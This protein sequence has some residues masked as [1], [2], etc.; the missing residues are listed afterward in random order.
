MLIAL[1]VVCDN[2]VAGASDECESEAR[3][4]LRFSLL[5]NAH[6]MRL[7]PVA[8][9]EELLIAPTNAQLLWLCVVKRCQV[10]QVR[11]ADALCLPHTCQRAHLPTLASRGKVK[12]CSYE[13][14][15][16]AHGPSPCL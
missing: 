11:F 9:T 10:T 16:P 4:N 2:V 7:R 13:R 6:G 1:G 14:C 12:R 15:E 5:A 8:H 3:K